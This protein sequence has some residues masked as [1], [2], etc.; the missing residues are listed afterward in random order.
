MVEFHAERRLL[1]IDDHQQ[2]HDDFF[3]IL[4]AANTGLTVTSATKL[5]GPTSPS[6]DESSASSLSLAAQSLAAQSLAAQSM[7]AQGVPAHSSPVLGMPV[8]SIASTYSGK[9][10][11]AHV[12][13]SVELNNR[14]SV[15][16]ID[17]QVSG[18]LDALTTIERIWAI[19]PA[20]QIVIC[21]SYTSG[22][23][24]S[25]VRRL[26]YSDQLLLLRQPM[27]NDELRQIA[28]AL[29]EKYRLSLRQAQKLSVLTKEVKKRRQMESELRE[30]AHRDALT[31]LPN[32]PFLLNRLETVLS[33][34]GSHRQSVDALLFMDLDNFK[35]I[36]DSLGHAAGD[37]LLSQVAQRLKQCLRD[38][39]TAARGSADL[40]SDCNETIT[41][42]TQED[43]EPTERTIRLGGDEF[44]VM[45]ER[46]THY[47]DAIRVARRIVASIAEP[48]RLGN[49]KV[50]VGTSVGIA[51][52]SDSIRDGHQLLSN[53]DTAMYQ[54][55]NLGKGRIAVFD[56]SMHEALVARHQLENKMREALRDD[57]LELRYQPIINLRSGEI[58]GVEVLSRW[59]SDDGEFVPPGTFIAMAEEI[60]LITQFGEWVL[61]RS[62][63]EFGQMLERFDPMH[64]PD[65][66]LG[67]N[68]S[69]K[70]LNDVIFAERLSGLIEQ[71]GYSPNL[72]I[73][74][75][76]KGDARDHERVLRTMHG[77]HEAGIGI[78]IDDFGKSSTSLTCFHDYPIET[79]KI[80][81]SFTSSI[82]D[83]HGRAIIMQAVIQLSHHLMANVVCEGVETSEQLELLQCWGCDLAQGFYFAPA[84]TIEELERL[85]RDPN[86]SHGLRELRRFLT[87]VDYSM[88]VRTPLGQSNAGGPAQIPLPSSAPILPSTGPYASDGR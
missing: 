56:Q 49:R 24:D 31:Q 15:A 42:E 44:V 53:A 78:H 64:Q 80:D 23:W 47:E 69:R 5:I 55:K 81:R 38:C 83:D 87:S 63:M 68:V 2:V 19:D 72:K 85:L 46:M 11:I 27:E 60:G 14:I 74:M 29:S 75:A 8:F 48:F 57:K 18:E 25:V 33:N 39:D 4:G 71:T 51:F 82:A 52:L 45:L 54:A 37:D 13:K 3:H 70:Q 61:R 6:T 40:K 35:V 9:Q 22:I 32:R 17:L 86:R 50:T 79:V 73:E 20:V 16:F 84:L 43:G 28:L 12:Q 34:Q 67:V 7:P 76:E 30:I 1:I 66:Y 62:I 58:Q 59:R 36:N 41:E 77:L 26:G 88:P 10:A 65:V 21:T